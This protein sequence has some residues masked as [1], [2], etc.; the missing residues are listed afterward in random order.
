MRIWVL[1]C[2]VAGREWK[3]SGLGGGGDGEEKVGWV[4]YSNNRQK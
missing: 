4:G 1:V 3:E 2:A